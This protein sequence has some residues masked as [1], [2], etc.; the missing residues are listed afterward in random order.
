[1]FVLCLFQE[2]RI[3]I[4]IIYI[5]YIYIYIKVITYVESPCDNLVFA[6]SLCGHAANSHGMFRADGKPLICLFAHAAWGSNSLTC[7]SLWG[8]LCYR[9]AR[10]IPWMFAGSHHLGGYMAGGLYHK[11][12]ILVHA[13]CCTSWPHPF[14]PSPC[15]PEKGT[16]MYYLCHAYSISN[17]ACIYCKHNLPKGIIKYCHSQLGNINSRVKDQCT[18]QI[19]FKKE[20]WLLCYCWQCYRWHPFALCGRSLGV[21][22]SLFVVFWFLLTLG[23][24]WPCG[25]VFWLFAFGFCWFLLLFLALLHQATHEQSERMFLW[26][27]HMFLLFFASPHNSSYVISFNMFTYFTLCFCNVFGE[28]HKHRAF[29]TISTI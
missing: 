28:F 6:W 9:C 13:A 2:I 29:G 3:Y 8:T 26:F 23:F 5:I 11:L 25:F 14:H 19:I 4:Y 20:C 18:L 27:F 7:A 17:A 22:F 16:T 1:M 10:M 21:A 24:F 15:H 12:S